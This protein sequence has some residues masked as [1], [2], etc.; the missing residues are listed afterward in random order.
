MIPAS[1][2]AIPKFPLNQNGKL[3]V[4]ALPEPVVKAPAARCL[5]TKPSSRSNR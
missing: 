2:V 5:M 1:I 4:A 3:D